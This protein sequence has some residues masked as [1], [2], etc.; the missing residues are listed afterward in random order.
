MKDYMAMFNEALEV[1]YGLG[2]EAGDIGGIN[3]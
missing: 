3:K 1:V 2:I